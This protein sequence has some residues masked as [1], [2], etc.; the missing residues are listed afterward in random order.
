MEDFEHINTLVA[1]DTARPIHGIHHF[2]MSQ[3]GMELFRN[4]GTAE[5]PEGT[6]I[7]GKV[8]KPMETSGGHYK[9]GDLAGYTMMKK[10]P[11]AGTTQATGGW[12]FVMF[13]PD[14]M[15]QDVDP[16][17]GCFGCHAPSRETD[18]V[19]STPLG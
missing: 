18:F 3:T 16:V 17:V 11:D 15:D 10:D 6:V 5:Y 12:H 14:R 19:L 9:E 2:Y 7:V 4:G 8:Y 13:G 1:P